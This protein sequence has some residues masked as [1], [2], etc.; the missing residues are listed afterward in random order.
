MLLE[1]VSPASVAVADAV[2]GDDSQSEKLKNE[3][4]GDEESA[5]DLIV[6]K[7]GFST[8]DQSY[9]F[10]IKSDGTGKIFY[11]EYYLNESEEF[12]HE[13]DLRELEREIETLFAEE[14]ELRKAENLSAEVSDLESARDEIAAERLEEFFWEE[15]NSTLED[16]FFRST[17]DDSEWG[18]EFHC[19]NGTTKEFEE[20]LR[21][22]VMTERAASKAVAEDYLIVTSETE[23]DAAGLDESSF[24]TERLNELVEIACEHFKPFGFHYDY[25][26]G[27]GD[28]YSGYCESAESVSV[29]VK[30]F[31]RVPAREKM[32]GMEK[33]KEKLAEMKIESERIEHLTAF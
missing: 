3:S 15:I 9:K 19:E 17:Y 13:I 22:C 27:C 6:L 20:F 12:S 7:G 10:E 16:P 32:L 25:N 28:R 14:V 1:N 33:L 4:N 8:S 2:K 31:A 11:S 24:Y 5:A 18:E 21:L 23:C 30:E 26:D 29:P